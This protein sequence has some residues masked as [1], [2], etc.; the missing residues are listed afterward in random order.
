MGG[1][2]TSV[3]TAWN[4]LRIDPWPVLSNEALSEASSQA[5]PQSCSFDFWG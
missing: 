3:G 1:G 4:C 2:G 5:V